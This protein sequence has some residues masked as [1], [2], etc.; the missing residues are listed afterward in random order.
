MTQHFIKIDGAKL[1]HT[2]IKVWYVMCGTKGKRIESA[3][4]VGRGPDNRIEIMSQNGSRGWCDVKSIFFTRAAA[5][6]DWRRRAAAETTEHADALIAVADELYNKADRI[7]ASARPVDH[8][9]N[10]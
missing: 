7:R 10:L 6:N 4:L 3:W 1:Y 8:F 5:S 9:H 2:G